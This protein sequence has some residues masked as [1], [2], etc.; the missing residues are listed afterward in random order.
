M[1]PISKRY[2]INQ[3]EVSGSSELEHLFPV[4]LIRYRI[5]NPEDL[6]ARLEARIREEMS[7]TATSDATNRG[8]SWRSNKQFLN[9]DGDAVS[10]LRGHMQNAVTAM[11]RGTVNNPVEEHF[12]DWLFESWVLL[13]RT[14]GFN[15]AHV[16]ASARFT[17]SGIYYAKT[18]F[19]PGEPVTKGITVLQDRSAVPKEI[20]NNPDP[21]ER[22][23]RIAPEA[24]M[25][26]VFPSTVWHYVEPF[27][28]DTERITI[29][30]NGTHSGFETPF[31]QHMSN[32]CEVTKENFMWRNFR[33]L[34]LITDWNYLKSRWRRR[35]RLKKGK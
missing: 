8:D 4:P 22:E 16:H 30:F 15:V 18:G 6:N 24:G 9:W 32:F 35:Q 17:W 31:Y 2:T 25:I 34:Q 28:G 14:G 23:Y 1:K 26:V 19:A 7:K 20:I 5:P 10:E 27:D 12:K 3:T 33:G 13:H 29:P 11:I 21:F